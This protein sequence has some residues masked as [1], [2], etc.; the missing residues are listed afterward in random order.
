MATKQ[1]LTVLK[2]YRPYQ[3]MM[4]AFNGHNFSDKS[5]RKLIGNICYMACDAAL[6]VTLTG[7]LLLSFWYCVE[8][9][10]NM[11]IISAGMPVILTISQLLLG[12][13]SLVMRNH[14]IRAIIDRLQDLIDKR[15]YLL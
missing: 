8:D 10:S 13:L 4:E 7:F 3:R 14:L 6:L 5:Y 1:P 15:E 12:Y 9:D 11:V 2:E